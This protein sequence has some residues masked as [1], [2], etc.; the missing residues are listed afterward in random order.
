MSATILVLANHDWNSTKRPNSNSPPPGPDLNLALPTYEAVPATRLSTSG[1]KSLDVQNAVV[2]ADFP[3]CVHATM[4]FCATCSLNT[5]TY[6]T[7]AASYSPS[8]CR[9]STRNEIWSARYDTCLWVDG[10]EFPALIH[11][12]TNTAEV[13]TAN[14][15]TRQC[16]LASRAGRL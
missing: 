6:T 8:A 7:T 11:Y 14:P 16:R 13:Q 5:F 9:T 2:V 4:Q 10:K 12:A 15:C 1:T 3:A